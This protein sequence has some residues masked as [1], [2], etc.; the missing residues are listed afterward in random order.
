LKTSFAKYIKENRPKK[1]NIGIYGSTTSAGLFVT[2]DR[3]F[4]FGGKKWTG[5]VEVGGGIVVVKF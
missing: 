1:N 3:L 4:L 5:G 2:I